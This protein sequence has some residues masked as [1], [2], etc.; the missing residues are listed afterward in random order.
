MAVIG[1]P[2]P[3]TGQLV[4]A[5]VQPAR[6]GTGSAGLAA[7]LIEHCRARVA[8]FTCPRS[9]EFAAESPRLPAGKLLRRQLRAE[10]QPA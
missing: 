8:T 1:V 7:E 3:E 6:Q 4:P 2:D 5:I 9:A 10:R